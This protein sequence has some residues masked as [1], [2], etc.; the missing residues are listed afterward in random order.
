MAWWLLHDVLEEMEQDKL[1]VS[2]PA[3]PAGIDNPT[4]RCKYG[5]DEILQKAGEYIS[6]TYR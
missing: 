6:T 3:A 4:I 1:I 5:E 2:K